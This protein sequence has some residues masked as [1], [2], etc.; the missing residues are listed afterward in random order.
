[1]RISV[2][3]AT[4]LRRHPHLSRNESAGSTGSVARREGIRSEFEVVGL[5]NLLRVTIGMICSVFI[6]TR[7]AR[8]QAD[9]YEH[10]ERN[11]NEELANAL[12]RL[13]H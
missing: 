8:P 9:T 7:R 5:G 3:S 6:G 13:L 4:A 10:R 12:H 1:M 2:T 11:Y